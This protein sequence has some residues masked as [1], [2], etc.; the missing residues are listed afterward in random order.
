RLE[1]THITISNEV[2]QPGLAVACGGLGHQTR[3]LAFSS[4]E[5]HTRRCVAGGSCLAT[6]GL[7]YQCLLLAFR[8]LDGCL[9]FTVSARYHGAAFALGSHLQVHG[10]DQVFW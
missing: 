3:C 9:A 2:A 10:P 1:C 8:T 5:L 4:R 7:Q 6:L